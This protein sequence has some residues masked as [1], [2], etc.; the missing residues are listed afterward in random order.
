VDLPGCGK[1][2]RIGQYTM[3]ILG[4]LMGV[5]IKF[6]NPNN[7]VILFG[8][9][10]GGHLLT[11]IPYKAN[12]YVL[13]GT[14]PLSGPDDFPNAFKPDSD[15]QY[16]IPYLSDPNP[17][18]HEIALK[19]TLHNFQINSEDYKINKQKYLATYPFLDE[20]IESAE[21][22]DGNFRQGCL[23]TLADKDQ[24]SW[25]YKQGQGKILIFHAIN[26][27]IINPKYLE[28]LPKKLLTEEKI[29][30]V[31]GPHISPLTQSNELLNVIERVIKK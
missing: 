26:D 5:V 9:S 27:G 31:D 14:P 1:S 12:L 10:L 18:S 4:D 3:S 20:M 6:F 30:Y 29:H 13:A 22:T 2:N 17:F 19:F 15:A 7:V 16:L 23:S 11:Y 8:H 25:M 28:S 21:K 24:I